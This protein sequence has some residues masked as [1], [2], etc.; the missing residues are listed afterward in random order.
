MLEKIYT[1][2]LLLFLCT[3][4]FAQ[5]SAPKAEAV[6]GGRITDIAAC[7]IDA[8]RSRVFITTE[9][10][11]SAFYADVDHSGANPVVEAFQPLTVLDAA[12]AMGPN[13]R[14]VDVV[15]N[16]GTFVFQHDNSLFASSEPY[17]EKQLISNSRVRDLYTSDHMLFYLD[18]DRLFWG[19]FDSLG[20]FRSS[21]EAPLNLPVSN[22]QMKI[23]VNPA[24]QIIY[25]CNLEQGKIFYTDAPYHSLSATTS[26]STVSIDAAI[27]N[28]AQWQAFGIAPD[29]RFF[30]GGN[31]ESGKYIAYSNDLLNWTDFSTTVPGV[32]APNFAFSGDA[33]AYHVYFASAYNHNKGKSGSWIPFGNFS[34]ETHPNDGPVLVDPINPSLVYLT[35]DQGIAASADG[36]TITYEINRGIEAVQV[37]DMDMT[38]DKTSAWIASKSGV[39]RV[40]NYPASPVWSRPMFPN[41][42]GSPYYST[43]MNLLDRHTVY[44]GNT[45]VYK[46]TN[47]GMNWNQVFTAESAPYHFSS[48]G[49]Q[50]SCLELPIENSN[51]VMAGYRGQQSAG[52]VFVSKDAGA[53]WEQILIKASSNGPDVNVNAIE[54]VIAET[55]TVAYVGVEYQNGGEYS[56]YKISKEGDEWT[57]EQDMDEDNT[58]NGNQIVVSIADLELSPDGN[59]LFATGTDAGN[60]HPVAYSKSLDGSGLWKPFTTNGFPT[61]SG[62]KGAAITIG[63][64]TLYCAVD[65]EIYYHEIGSDTWQLGYAYPPGTE[66]N[67]LYFDDLLAG[68]G[69]GL[70]GHASQGGTTS[71]EFE[72]AL[73]TKIPI[74]VAP[75]P[76]SGEFKFSFALPNSGTLRIA[77]YDNQGKVVYTIFRERMSPGEY[78]FSID[79]TDWP[80]GVYR[81]SLE[82]SEGVST[83]S[84]VKLDLSN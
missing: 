12:A 31:N 3:S 1:S 54:I 10:A 63:R 18:A 67:F 34:Q 75:N 77:V 15:P 78:D 33:A 57:V 44:V 4:L 40:D 8:N 80:A 38:L 21:A 74:T 68:T 41:G 79:S 62:K 2:L 26:F 6:F 43:A 49:Y 45:R 9:S 11:N 70:Y 42:D 23:Q 30:L 17:A 64:D 37:K 52:G 24:D 35:S 65:H 56:I 72:P 13:V 25:I 76:V 82:S 59:T 16:T 60:N 39:R 84:I 53:T 48:V 83:V 36:G 47:N 29:G 73:M 20:L 50:V 28:A 46:T 58:A 66:I 32:G 55:D 14:M 22:G 81:L 71:N 19:Q 5:I 7:S 61:L 69:T 51:L 27:M